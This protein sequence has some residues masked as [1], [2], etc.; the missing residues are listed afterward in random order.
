MQENSEIKSHISQNFKYLRKKE[1]LSQEEMAAKFSLSRDNIMSYE[2]GTEPKIGVLKK[3]ADHYGYTIDDIYSCDLNSHVFNA[4]DFPEKVRRVHVPKVRGKI[5]E[6]QIIPLYG[7]DAA[8]SIVQLYN[9]VHSHIP[10]GTL[11]IPNLAPSDG[12]LNITGDS[13]YPLLKSGDIVVFKLVNTIEK[14]I[15]FG[16]MY[17]VSMKLD[18]SDY[19]TSV[20]FVQR[21]DQGKEYVKLVSQNQHHQPKDVLISDIKAL[22][23]VIASV[24]L[25]T[26]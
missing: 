21:S 4:E 26:M 2:R 8:A 23:L 5:K 6:Q 11:S 10:I 14:N 3:I 18:S 16:E 9:D 7:M 13:M 12:A 20:K 24:R 15:F 1:G 17:I 25:N 22:A 19:Y